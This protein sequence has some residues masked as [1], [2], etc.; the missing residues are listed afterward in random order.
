MRRGRASDGVPLQGK[1]R[2]TVTADFAGKVSVA[3][4]RFA[5]IE[6]GTVTSAAITPPGRAWSL[7]KTSAG[8]R[9]LPI[10]V[11]VGN[12]WTSRRSPHS[13]AAAVPAE[14]VRHWPRDTLPFGFTSRARTA[15]A[16]GAGTETVRRSEERRVGKECRSR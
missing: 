12:E 10:V 6:A 8:V 13:E 14:I 15:R 16:V 1:S 2:C 5:V 7:P 9:A 4:T 11:V 3:L